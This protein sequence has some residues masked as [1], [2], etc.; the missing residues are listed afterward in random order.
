MSEE[1]LIRAVRD[2]DVETIQAILESGLSPNF[3]D[4]ETG[5]S[6]LAIACVDGY[7]E[8]VLAL[9]EGGAD[10][11]SLATVTPPINNAA[12]HGHSDIVKFLLSYDSECDMKGGDGEAALGLAASG[13]YYQI[14]EMLLDAGANAKQR[15][16]SGSSPINDA[17]AK[18]HRDIVELLAPVSTKS[19]QQSAALTLRYFNQGPANDEVKS[20]LRTAELGSID[21]IKKY[22][23]AGGDVDAVNQSGYTAL[24]F[25][26]WRGQNE[27]VELLL[28]KGADINHLN[29]YG[30]SV[31]DKALSANRYDTSVSLIPRV[32]KSIRKK[33]EKDLPFFTI[34]A[35][36][37]T[38]LRPILAEVV[39]SPAFESACKAAK[40]GKLDKVKSFVDEC[41]NIDEMDKEGNTL[42]FYAANGG[43]LPILHEILAHS[44][45]VNHLNLTGCFPLAAAANAGR[46]EAYDLL[47]ELTDAKLRPFAEET[48]KFVCSRSGWFIEGRRQIY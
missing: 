19:A 2:S 1:L 8:V 37:Q 46:G 3:M 38:E 35:A 21:E 33:H 40:Q 41:S 47:Y 48:K 10:P 4:D 9:L 31:I 28:E 45:D 44:P 30:Y 11:N 15:D 36:R 34:M 32:D 22:L 25:A 5:D 20:F 43:E 16:S 13:G 26:A 27:V 17:A 42:L 6:P 7:R 18:G 12:G 39:P 23:D 14:V 24:L 29:A